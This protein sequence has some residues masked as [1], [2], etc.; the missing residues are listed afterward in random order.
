MLTTVPF[1]LA[2]VALKL[3]LDRGLQVP[4]WLE[5]GDVGPVLTGGVFLI[6]FM[7]AGTMADYKES[8]KLPG[9]VCCALEAIEEVF[10]QAAAAKPAVALEP[11]RRSLLETTDQIRA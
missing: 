5:M 9:E 6:G 3:V 8:E 1:M 11:L 7:L 2:A 10:G 4:G